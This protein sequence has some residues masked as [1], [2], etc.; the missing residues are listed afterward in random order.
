M[1]PILVL[2]MN[3]FVFSLAVLFQFNIAIAQPISDQIQLDVGGN[4]VYLEIEGANHE[5]PVLLYLHGGPG[6]VALGIPPFRDNVGKYLEEEFL[7]VYLHQRGVGKSSEVPESELT[8]AHHVDDVSK[9]VDFV[10][11][12]YDQEKVLLIGHSWGGVLAALYTDRYQEKVEA[13]VFVASPMNMRSTYQD[14]HEFTLNWARE[15]NNSEAINQLAPIGQ[16]IETIESR[17]ILNRW[18]NQAY[19]GIGRSVDLPVLIQ[20]YN[21]SQTYPNWAARQ[22]KINQAMRGEISEIDLTNAIASFSIPALFVAGDLDSIVPAESVRRDY[23][24]Y[25][26]EKTFVVLENSHHLPFVD[27]PAELL[28]TIHSFLSE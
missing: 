25:A 4:S 23:D 7:I 6:N 9:V 22:S 21:I 13:V 26:G 12:R 16:N 17:R 2:V 20:R 10:T 19:G 8:I 5:A 18:A 3:K 1:H 15:V 27:Q 14:S 28:N 24:N 11:E